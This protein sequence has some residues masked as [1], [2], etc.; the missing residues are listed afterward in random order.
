MSDKYEPYLEP[1]FIPGVLGLFQVLVYEYHRFFYYYQ[2]LDV[3]LGY[4][5]T[6]VLFL[7]GPISLVVLVY[8]LLLVF[9]IL[10]PRVFVKSESGFYKFFRWPLAGVGVLTILFTSA[11]W[12]IGG[13]VFLTYK[14]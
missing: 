11:F 12:L 6:F 13:Y 1:L 8:E 4:A 5:S 9:K 3:I 10:K 2:S 7:L 14:G